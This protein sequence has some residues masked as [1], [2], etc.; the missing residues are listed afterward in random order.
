MA[1][2]RERH[3]LAEGVHRHAFW[4]YGVIVGLAIDKALSGLIPH[5]FTLPN[6]EPW[7]FLPEAARF[8]VFIILIVRFY[9]GSALYFNDAYLSDEATNLYPRKSYALDFLFGFAHFLFFYALGVSIE[10]HN[11]PNGIF[12]VLLVVILAYDL[13]WFLASGDNDTRHLIKMWAFVNLITLLVSLVCYLVVNRLGYNALRA[14]ESAFIPIVIVSIIDFAEMITQRPVFS[15][16]L[17]RLATRQ[18]PAPPSTT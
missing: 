15:E 8:V 9:L 11:K 13:L 10:I 18:P 12:P 2:S 6:D 14:E 3:S 1:E 5:I 7:P 4:V 17:A 16:W